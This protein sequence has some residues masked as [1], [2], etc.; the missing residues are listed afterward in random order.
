MTSDSDLLAHVQQRS[1]APASSSTPVSNRRRLVSWS[2]LAIIFVTL[3]ALTPY[4]FRT[5]VNAQLGL[6][7]E[8][9]KIRGASERDPE[10]TTREA[11]KVVLGLIAVGGLLVPS[12]RRLTAAN[13]AAWAGLAFLL[14]AAASPLW[15]D[16]PQL[17]VRRVLS[18]IVVSTLAVS[19]ARFWDSREVLAGIIAAM[20]AM[21][22]LSLGTELFFGVFTPFDP[23]YR[24]AGVSH[25][26]DVAEVSGILLVSA[27]VGSMAWPAWRTRLRAVAGLSVVCLLLTRSRGGTA[28]AAT[29]VALLMAI[30]LRRARAV[31]AVASLAAIGAVVAL[32]LFGDQ[33]RDA[34]SQAVLMGRTAPHEGADVGTFTGRTELWSQLWRFVQ[35]SPAIGYGYDSFWSPARM[36]EILA[37]QGWVP[38]TAHSG[39]L[40]M[41]LSLGAV[42]LVP[43]LALL[44]SAPPL[45]LRRYRLTQD[46][47]DLAGAVILPLIYVDMVIESALEGLTLPGLIAFVAIASAVYVRPRGRTSVQCVA[48]RD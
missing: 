10:R 5:G 46:P 12:R 34:L 43:W 1:T 4:N 25:P 27:L 36:L 2:I 9:A 16:D 24:F 23:A 6:Q 44:A 41:L 45:L 3:I 18:L 28:A 42:G 30:R 20:V 13:P 26:N 15:S 31:L 8:E 22:T 17:T 48:A 7:A 14:M 40:D 21:L 29:A 38:G 32:Y 11:L 19:I 35:Y 47:A 39:Y 37:R 33:I